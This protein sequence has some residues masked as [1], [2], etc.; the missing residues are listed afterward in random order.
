MPDGQPD[1]PK[2]AEK[3]ADLQRRVEELE[4]SVACLAKLA[5]THSVTLTQI[6]FERSSSKI[7]SQVLLWLLGA[8]AMAACIFCLPLAKWFGSH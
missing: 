4:E 2:G 8:A 7:S 3:L 5:K 6:G 1:S